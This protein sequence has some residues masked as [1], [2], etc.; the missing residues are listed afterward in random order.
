MSGSEIVSYLSS[1]GP[2]GTKSDLIEPWPI[3]MFLFV[4]KL[5][6]LLRWFIDRLLVMFINSRGDEFL[7]S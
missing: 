3:W 2:V 7:K 1:E 6:R 5:F 4:D